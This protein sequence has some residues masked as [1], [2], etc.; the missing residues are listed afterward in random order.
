MKKRI[1]LIVCAV[2]ALTAAILVFPALVSGSGVSESDPLVSM[3]YLSGA[4]KDDLLAQAKAQ[5]DSVSQSL[6]QQM[7]SHASALKASVGGVSADAT[8]HTPVTIGAGSAYT[9]T[10]G[11]EFL[12]LSGNVRAVDA[13]LTDSTAGEAVAA[14]GTLSENHLYITASSVVLQTDSEARILIR[15]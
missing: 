3:S 8:T 5:T 11:A 7:Q 1:I 4:Y 15:K 10:D 13:G 12:L 14:N 9:V 2:A 6:Q